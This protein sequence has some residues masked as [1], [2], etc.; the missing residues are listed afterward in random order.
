MPSQKHLANINVGTTPNSQDGDLLRDAFIKV[1][2]NFDDIYENGQFYGYS[3]DNRLAPGFSWSNDRDTGMHHPASGRISFSLNGAD[4]LTLNENGE[5]RWFS[6]K[7]STENYVN[8]SLTA[9]TGGVSAANIS[10]VVG[11]GT[12]NV[13]INGM[14]VVSSLP[15]LGNHEGRIVF[16]NGDI[17]IFSGYPV[18]NGAGRA[19][20]PSIARLAG[21]DFRWVRFRGDVA[22]SIGVVRPSVA[23]EGTIFYETANAIPY[24]Y[25][26]GIW[27][28]LNSLVSTN[29]PAG[30][31]VLGSLPSVGDTANYT[32]RT[33]VV[34]TIAYIFIG[35]VWQ[36]LSTYVSGTS[37]GTG[38]ASGTA[39]PSTL[40]ANVGELFRR[41]G[42]GAGLYIF[43]GS[44][45]QTLPQFTAN[46]VTARIPTLLSLP[47]DLTFYNPGD[48]II[49][50]STS[51][52]LNTTKTSWQ[53]YTPGG[54]GGTITGIAL[55]P[56]QVSNVEL[57]ANAVIASKIATNVIIGSKLVS[58]TIT[59]REIS[60]LSITS[61]KIASNA[62]T[63]SKI[64]NN[65]ITGDKL[66]A[67]SING[68]KIVF[69]TIERAQLA[70]NIFT[71]I[72][73][74]ANSLSEISQ[75]LGTVTS[76]V[77]RSSDGRMVID[78]N[79]KFIRIEI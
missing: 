31:Q 42:T 69:G 57:A 79:N 3:V 44:V 32:G 78:L 13:T 34:G 22:F 21:S 16:F 73:V 46:T 30:L 8:T 67:N 9:F 14:P 59:T 20:E 40:T 48:L 35:G 66:A 60:G 39:F 15:T 45:W 6:E 41:T 2:Q 70:P 4:S 37:S 63:T 53:F 23:P 10:V 26:S 71:S 68:S 61:D 76:G 17:W 36:T 77:M 51:Y 62:V 74:S 12:A 11:S 38:I 29:A 18:G 43:N 1:N 65:S 27:R 52:I 5:L 50:G 55:N 49:V 47:T 19:A 24:V 72:S 25:L 33:V 7:L 28:T 64:Q 75:N 58:N 54:G 56:G